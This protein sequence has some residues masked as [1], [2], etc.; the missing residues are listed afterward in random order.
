[1]IANSS[2]GPPPGMSRREWREQVPQTGAPALASSAASSSASA[3][4]EGPLT[5]LVVCTGNIC[6]SPMAEAV[7]R[8]RLGPLGV[9]VHSAGTHALVDHEM[10]EPAQALAVKSGAHV[11]DAAS[12]AARYLVEPMLLGADL[13]L[14]MTREHRSHSVKM[15]PSRVRYTFTVREFARLASALSDEEIRAAS[16]VAGAGAGDRFARVLQAIADRRGLTAG[17]VDPAD[18]DVID[19]YR[20]PQEVYDQAAAQLIPALDEVERVVRVALG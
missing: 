7:L 13:V 1:M 12:H 6:R 18:D 19:P 9:R 16:D 3:T 10:T 8:A 14:T 20:R 15:V 5:I 17:A 11:A 2:A 4:D